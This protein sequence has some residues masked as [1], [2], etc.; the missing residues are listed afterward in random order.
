MNSLGKTWRFLIQYKSLSLIATRSITWILS[1]SPF[2][3][4]KTPIQLPHIYNT[5]KT[6]LQLECRTYM[7]FQRYV[8]FIV[9]TA[10][11]KMN[12]LSSLKDA[13]RLPEG[14]KRIAYDSDTMKFLFRDCNGQLYQGEAGAEYGGI[15]TLISPSTTC[16]SRSRPDAFASG[17]SS[18]PFAIQTRLIHRGPII[19]FRS[20]IY[21]NI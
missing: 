20:I 13:E 12:V 17:T 8:L 1:N 7:I 6:R 3:R 14:F 11:A 2:F 18:T 21:T 9:I 5:L 19:R 4:F 16:L 15:M 10:S